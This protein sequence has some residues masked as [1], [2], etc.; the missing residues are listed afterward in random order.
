MHSLKLY[1]RFV[2]YHLPK[3]SDIYKTDPITH[4]DSPSFIKL[5]II[6]VK[7]L[8]VLNKVSGQLLRAL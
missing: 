7:N 2:T 5:D 4:P 3:T 1:D 8:Q 6:K